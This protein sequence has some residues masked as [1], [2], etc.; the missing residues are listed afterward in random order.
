MAKLRR[1]LPAILVFAILVGMANPTTEAGLFKKIVRGVK[2][3]VSAPVKAVGWLVGQGVNS[4]VDPAMDNAFGQLRDVSDHA[5]NRMDTITGARMTELSKLANESITQLDKVAENRLGQLDT[6]MKTRLD[7]VDTILDSKLDRVESLADHVLNREAEIL[8]KTL[9]DAEKLANNSLDRLQE[10][11]TDAFDRIDAALQDQVPFA[12]SQVAQTVE[13]TAAII[14]FLVVLVGYGGVS[15]IR[16][17]TAESEEGWLTRLKSNLKFVPKTLLTVGVPMLFLFV[18]IQ[19]GYW[20]YCSKVEHDRFSR[21]DSASELLEQV[22]D[23]RAAHKIRRRAFSL[24]GTKDRHYLV[25]R[26]EWL[27]DFWQRRVGQDVTELS[28]RLAQLLS[29]S[30]YSQFAETDPEI[31]AASIYLQSTTL[32]ISD[33]F[34]ANIESQIDEYKKSFLANPD[35]ASPTLGKLVYMAETRI[36]LNRSGVPVIKRLNEALKSVEEMLSHS[37][38][39]KYATAILLRARLKTYLLELKTDTYLAEALS[40]ADAIEQSQDIGNDIT[41]A[42]VIDPNLVRFIRFRSL[43]LSDVELGQSPKIGLPQK[44]MTFANLA[45]ADRAKNTALGNELNSAIARLEIELKDTIRPLLKDE[46][47]VRAKVERQILRALKIDAGEATLKSQ[48]GLARK[49]RASGKT[50]VADL[51]PQYQKVIETAISLDNLHT[52]ELYLEE[53]KNAYIKDSP[54]A[55]S[56]DQK[57][58]VDEKQKLLGSERL[59]DVMFD[60]I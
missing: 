46:K 56:E 54:Q 52:A 1:W 35:G 48:I 53:V 11:E 28:G 36:T 22:G 43:S 57:K 21:L 24:D 39:K 44:L 58:F 42:L 2:S 13:W 9:A 51:F 37:S 59:A 6:I 10:I 27:A 29:D 18:V 40:E 20:G 8:D 12:A 16:R 49:T 50:S 4:A 47:L 38:Y 45:A 41:N 55:L 7:Q 30:G 5:L 31:L 60:L 25:V 19:V 23:F 3:V 33:A 34:V 17:S 32:D 14:I 15:L 26:N